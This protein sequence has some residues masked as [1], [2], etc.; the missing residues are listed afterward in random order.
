[1]TDRKWWEDFNGISGNVRE[2]EIGFSDD[3]ELEIKYG[4]DICNEGYREKHGMVNWLDC[5]IVRV[6]ECF[7]EFNGN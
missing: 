6:M 1:M 7:G 5:E 2:E 4:R 3:M